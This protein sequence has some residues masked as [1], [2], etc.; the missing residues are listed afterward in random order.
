M[1]PIQ[2]TAEYQQITAQST[3]TVMVFSADWCPDCRYLDTYIDEVVEAYQGRLEFYLVNRD[4]YADLC[5]SLD[6]LG[7][8]SFIVYQ[9]G[10]EVDRFVNSKRKF[11]PE[12]V[13]FLDG[14]LQE[15]KVNK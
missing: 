14:T 7:I 3:P 6:V 12:V 1:K 9:S 8:P 15:L 13:A 10:Q 2:S 4:E 11:K 5:E